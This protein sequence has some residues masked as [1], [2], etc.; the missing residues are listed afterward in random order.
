MISVWDFY[1]RILSMTILKCQSA[2][3]PISATELLQQAVEMQ[4]EFGLKCQEILVKGMTLPE[5]TVV[6][7]LSI[8]GYKDI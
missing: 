2:S 6:V 7:L 1:Q 8:F 5:E 3:N 4:T